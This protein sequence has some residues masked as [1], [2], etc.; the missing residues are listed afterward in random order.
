[1]CKHSAGLSG[2]R[3][4]PVV[5]CDQLSRDSL[6]CLNMLHTKTDM[7]V[8]L[9]LGPQHAIVAKLSTLFVHSRLPTAGLKTQKFSLADKSRPILRGTSDSAQGASDT[10]GFYASQPRKCDNEN[11]DAM[12]SRSGRQH[13]RKHPRTITQ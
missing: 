6:P 7:T 13:H 2:R 5:Q 3:A 8:L 10:Y 1:M 4:G 9:H 11:R 12:A